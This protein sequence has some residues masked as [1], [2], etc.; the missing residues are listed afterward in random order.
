MRR[1]LATVLV[2]AA[3]RHPI[4]TVTGPRQSGKTTL[5]RALFPRKP[6]VT[7]ER[8]DERERVR[9]DPRGF[10]ADHPGGAILDEVQHVPDLLSYLQAEV[11]EDPRPGRW[12]L[13]GSQHFGLAS[14]VAQSLAGRTAIFHLLA[15]SRDELARFPKPPATLLANLLTGA[16][17]R[18]HDQS[19]SPSRWL[20]D[21]VATYVQ[22]DV[23]QVLEVTNLAAF[24]TFVRLAAGRTAQEVNLS[25]LGSDAGVSHLTARSWL[26]ALEASFLVTLVPAWHRTTRKRLVRRPKLHWLDSGLVCHLLGI[27]T[28]EQLRLHPLRGAIFESWVVSEV[29]KAHANRGVE[30]RLYHLRETR[31]VELDLLVEH[32]RELRG[33]ECKSGATVAEDAFRG[34]LALPG[35]IGAAADVRPG[36][37]VYGGDTAQRRHEHQ[38]VPWRRL[39]DVSWLKRGA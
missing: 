4:V 22:R 12:V 33:I 6:Y 16:Y 8:L 39:P 32:G 1:N 25:A 13:T 31:G 17:P 15:P 5:C 23:R 28:E 37:L 35:S 7:F 14:S 29:V 36:V 19:L 10:L 20:G 2:R 27:T 3:R 38:V 18:I 30:P 24:T 11:D 21:Y 34:L 9:A 26:T